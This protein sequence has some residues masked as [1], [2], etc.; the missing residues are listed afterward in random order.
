MRPT[1]PRLAATVAISA[2]LLAPAAPALAAPAAPVASPDGLTSAL[3][4]VPTKVDRQVLDSLGAFA[5][6]I[7]GSMAT[8]GPDGK[9][10][11]ALFADA[12]TLGSNPNLPPQVREV[13]REIIDFLGEP[14]KRSVA[15]Y[16]RTNRLP[17]AKKKAKPGD[18][19]IP[20]GPG[21]PRIQEFLYP[22]IGIGC[23]PES[24]TGS[25]GSL[26]G[27]NSLGRALVT[28][29]PQK[30]PAPGPKRG[31]VGYVY[32]SLGTGP[33]VNNRAR[34]LIAQWLNLDT[35][36]TGIINLRRNPKINATDGP[37]TFTAIA[38]TGRGRVLTVISGDVT[39]KTKSKRVVSCGIV[40]V[41]GIAYV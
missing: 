27:G 41:I 15:A 1:L 25:L 18:P 23:M 36:R 20:R 4:A 12:N 35:G 11:P 19:E 21:A 2:G 17:V 13:W 34:P 8:P 10:N 39:V 7:I 29:G 3:A 40:P 38:S 9:V 14:G 6:A 31:Q 30:A 22:T 33:A 37:G 32:T 16:H 28:A 24:A 26:G 5:P